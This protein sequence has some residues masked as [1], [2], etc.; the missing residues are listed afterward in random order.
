V[1][2]FRGFAKTQL[3]L[4]ECPTFAASRK[5]N[6]YCLS[7]QFSRCRENSFVALFEC[8][9]FAVS[10]K[11]ILY[12]LSVQFS[13]CRENSFCIVRV[14]NFRG[15]AKTQFVLFECT[16]FAVSRK[17]I[18]ALSECPTFAVSQKLKLCCLSLKSSRFREAQVVLFE[19]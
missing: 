16:I 12:C 6:L 3:V 15:F 4:L 19:S 18:F 11:L 1:S 14:S 7:V 17:L 5:L 2:T 9:I 10:R 8:P 13:R